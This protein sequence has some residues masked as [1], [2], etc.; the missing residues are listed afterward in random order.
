MGSRKH[1]IQEQ[2]EVI[3]KLLSE[4]KTSF[5]TSNLEPSMS[6]DSPMLESVTVDDKRYFVLL[7]FTYANTAR[8]LSELRECDCDFAVSS[9]ND[10]NIIN[11]RQRHDTFTKNCAKCLKP[12]GQIMLS[13]RMLQKSQDK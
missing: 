7:S 3:K 1:C 4:D 5:T 9:A 11:K 12:V 6:T 2:R 10:V 13:I 8:L